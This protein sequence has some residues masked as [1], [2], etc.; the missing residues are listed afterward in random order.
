MRVKKNKKNNLSFRKIVF[1]VVFSTAMAFAPVASQ[2]SEAWD[3]IP[4]AIYKQA[5]ETIADRIK[6]II[7]GALKKQ[8]AKMLN[9]QTNKLLGG[10]GG[11][12]GAGFITN[13]QDYLVKQPQ[14]NTKTYMNDYLS[15]VT[16]GKGSTTSYKSNEGIGGMLGGGS[17][18]GSA[19]GSLLGS[20]TGSGGGGSYSSQLVNMAKK[21]TVNQAQPK[22]TFQGSPS[23]MF[24]KGNFKQFDSFLSGINNPWM[25]DANAQTEYQKK[26]AEEKKIAQTKAIS[27]QGFKGVGEDKKGKGTI[28]APGSLVKDNTANTQDIG[29]KII[30]SA[31]HPEEVISAIMTQMINQMMTQGIG[32]IGQMI[33]KQMGQTKALNGVLKTNV[34]QNGP[35]AAYKS[36]SSGININSLLK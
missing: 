7:M 30:A 6:G 11:K 22:M 23:Q 1:V 24:A 15:K 3:A 19:S 27:Y 31:Q 21:D 29:N 25:F 16:A 13:W 8:A 12:G 35:G 20:L 10:K 17:S 34:S 14:N 4:A 5:L 28:K 33:S 36:T 32:N 9:Q 26:L 2:K 18:G